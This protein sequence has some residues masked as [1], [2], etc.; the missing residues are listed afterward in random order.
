MDAQSRLDIFSSL[1]ACDSLFQDVQIF[2]VLNPF[3]VGLLALGLV[4]AI[5]ACAIINCTLT[6]RSLRLSTCALVAYSQFALS[7]SSSASFACLAVLVSL[8]VSDAMYSSGVAWVTALA[9]G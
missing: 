3:S 9:A 6:F 8:A 7:T 4:N 2:D 1:N 5:D